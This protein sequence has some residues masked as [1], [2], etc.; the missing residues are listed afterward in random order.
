ME[1]T[2]ILLILFAFA[3]VGWFLCYRARSDG[4]A[5]IRQPEPEANDAEWAVHY[6]HLADEA[7]RDGDPDRAKWNRVL[8]ESYEQAQDGEN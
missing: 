6:R 5:P 3:V 1:F 4:Q 2:V 7:Q 8:A